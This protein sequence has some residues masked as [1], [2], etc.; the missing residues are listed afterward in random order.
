MVFMHLTA[1]YLLKC[2]QT[3]RQEILAAVHGSIWLL[4]HTVK[5]E[6]VLPID[7]NEQ[8]ITAV[9]TLTHM[10]KITSRQLLYLLVLPL[11]A[12]VL[13]KMV[14]YLVSSPQFKSVDS[15]S[16]EAERWRLITLAISP[17]WIWILSVFGEPRASSLILRC[18]EAQWDG[19]LFNSSACS[20]RRMFDLL[21]YGDVWFLIPNKEDLQRV[22]VWQSP[23]YS[24]L[25]KHFPWDLVS[26]VLIFLSPGW[27]SLFTC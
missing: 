19:W 15:V 5:W 1:F 16:G 9:S 22:N 27:N 12:L 4:K 10:H 26:T 6:T 8:R 23:S 18:R 20:L 3:P 14:Y 25:G 11:V 13:H 17:L 24:A 7:L 21:P 2:W